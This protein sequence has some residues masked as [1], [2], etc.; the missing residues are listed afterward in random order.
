MV[1]HT[2]EKAFSLFNNKNDKE[3]KIGLILLEKIFESFS[4]IELTEAWMVSSELFFQ[5]GVGILTG[6]KEHYSQNKDNIIEE[7][8]RYK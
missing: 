1:K 5:L 8:K 2:V 4:G 7:E 6:L 3:I